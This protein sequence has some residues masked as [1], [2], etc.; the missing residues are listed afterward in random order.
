GRNHSSSCCIK[1]PSSHHPAFLLHQRTVARTL[2]TSFSPSLSKPAFVFVKKHP[3]SL[4]NF[5]SPH[6]TSQTTKKK[7][8]SKNEVFYCRRFFCFCRR[9]RC[10][11]RPPTMPICLYLPRW[12]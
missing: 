9:S 2:V 6:K 12:R 7:A 5:F 11:V 3:L 8:L 10:S 1:Y 4:R